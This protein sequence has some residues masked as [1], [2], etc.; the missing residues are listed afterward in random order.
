M[1]DQIPTC[2]VGK[3]GY[4]KIHTYAFDSNGIS[5]VISTNPGGHI[6]LSY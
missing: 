4:D 3:V 1:I 6:L 2:K 5:S